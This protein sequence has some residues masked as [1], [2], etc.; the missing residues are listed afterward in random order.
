M[1]QITNRSQ[2]VEFKV[3]ALRECPV[4]AELAV[5]ETPEDALNYWMLHVA[6]DVKFNPECECVVVLLLNTRRKVKGH[7]FLSIGTM[8][9]ILVH[10]REVFRAAIVGAAA[11]VLLMHNHPSGEAD[12]SEADIR[13]TR[14][15]IRAGQIVRIELVDHVIVGRGQHRSLR[16][17]GVF[18]S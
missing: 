13:V 3:I 2:P 5:C 8:D 4:P 14:D 15:L 7:V 9:A 10:P 1:Q 17:L 16:E 6:V 11:A 18:Y 12:P